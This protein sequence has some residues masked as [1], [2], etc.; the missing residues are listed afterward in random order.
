MPGWIKLHRS[1]EDWE[2]YTAP[3]HVFVFVHLLMKANH[4]AGSWRGIKYERGD[5]LTSLDKLSTATGL[6]KQNIRTILKNLESTGE[7]MRKP[8]H[9]LTHLSICNYNTYQDKE[10]QA[11][12]ET[13]TRLTRSQHE[14]N[15]SL[16]PNNNNKNN[17]E[18]KEQLESSW[19]IFWNDYPKK[20]NNVNAKK[21]LFK[22]LEQGVTIDQIC[23]A[24]NKS[25]SLRNERQ[26]IPNPQA[27]LNKTPW[28]DEEFKPLKGIEMSK[29]EK[30]RQW[31]LK[32]T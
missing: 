9:G 17:K 23:E 16:T 13:N 11:N 18:L 3:N 7:T 10:L 6:T 19:E 1:M 4:E 24:M 29:E 31:R 22:Y 32:H 12:T 2:W 20:T 14:T 5:V 30:E 26:F 25:E 27:W 8:T 15:T 28:L 21:T